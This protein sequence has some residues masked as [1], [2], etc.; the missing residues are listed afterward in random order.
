MTQW[1]SERVRTYVTLPWV[2]DYSRHLHYLEDI[3]KS[4][5][6][7]TVRPTVHTNPFRKWS[8]WKTLSDQGNLKATPPLGFCEPTRKHFE[9]GVFWKRWRHDNH[10]ISLPEVFFSHTNP[11]WRVIVCV[12]KFLRR[13]KDWDIWCVFRVKTPFSNSSGVVGTAP[14]TPHS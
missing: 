7:P 14:N 2:L 12:F 6:L 5:V 9:N 11:K 8:F 4:N 10:V 13:R 3:W 1:R